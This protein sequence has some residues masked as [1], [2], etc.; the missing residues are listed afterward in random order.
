MGGWIGAAGL[1]RCVFES[2][3]GAFDGFL[4]FWWDF[5]VIQLR[6]FCP[7]TE[8]RKTSLSGLKV[9]WRAGFSR[10]GHCLRQAVQGARSRQGMRAR[11]AAVI[12]DRG[13]SL[14]SVS[15]LA[16]ARRPGP[17]RRKYCPSMAA[18]AWFS[19]RGTGER[20]PGYTKPPEVGMGSV[21]ASVRG[22]VR[23]GGSSGLA[24]ILTANSQC[25]MMPHANNGDP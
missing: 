7:S 23:S 4:G 6:A 21:F 19:S 3:R 22:S 8:W 2:K 1:F 17:C 18:L 14:R 20:F 25:I 16:W 13:G 24:G 15:G 11:L 5:G 12:L 10:V 9:G